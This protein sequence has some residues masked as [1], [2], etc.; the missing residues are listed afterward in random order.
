MIEQGHKYA[1]KGKPVI[2]LE[3]GTAPFMVKVLPVPGDTYKSA[4]Y[5]LACELVPEPM[6]YLGGQTAGEVAK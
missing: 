1:H 4:Y 5:V 3:S 6:K 2:A